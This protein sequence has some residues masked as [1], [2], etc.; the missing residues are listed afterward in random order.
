MNVSSR[1]SPLL[2]THPSPHRC[3]IPPPEALTFPADLVVDAIQDATRCPG[4]GR[5]NQNLGDLRP[6]SDQIHT[7]STT[8]KAHHTLPALRQLLP[9][10]SANLT[11]VLMQNGMG[12]YEEIISEIFRNPEYRPR[13]ILTSNTHDAFLRKP[14]HVVHSDLVSIEFAIAPDPGGKTLIKASRKP[15]QRAPPNPASQI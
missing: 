8:T 7:L 3:R 1:A 4:T 6:V 9:R 12:V 14:N 5:R 10:P 15:L 13:F 2:P 11:T